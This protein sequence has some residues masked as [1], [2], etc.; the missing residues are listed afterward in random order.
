VSGHALEFLDGARWFSEAL[1][2]ST[3]LATVRSDP[4]AEGWTHADGAIGHFDIGDAGK[5]DLAL[6]HEA[7]Q[8]VIVEA[9]MFAG[10]STGV[11]NADYLDQAA[12]TVACMAEVLRRAERPASE[13]SR[14]GFC[15]LAREREVE[16]GSFDEYM[17]Q[18]SMSTNVGRRVTEWLAEHDDDK[19][20]WHSDWFQ[21]LLGEVQPRVLTWEQVA[22]T[23]DEH[24]AP[25]GEAIGVFYDRCLQYN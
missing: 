24:D 21:P 20:Q 25:A 1:L 12:R 8:L 9:K 23:I 7:E 2:P 16:K 3:F 4:L 11:T 17:D 15:V 5:G 6:R 14:L 10:L 13:M 22:A 18:E 19:K